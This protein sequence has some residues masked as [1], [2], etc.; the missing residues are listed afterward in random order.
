MKR[1]MT[2]LLITAA[3]TSAVIAQTTPLTAGLHQTENNAD[4]SYTGAGWSTVIDGDYSYMQS[5]QVGDLMSLEFNGSSIVLFRDMVTAPVTLT[6][7]G[8]GMMTPLPIGDVGGV[9]YRQAVQFSP[10]STGIVP[11]L[12]SILAITIITQRA[13]LAG[14]SEQIITMRRPGQYW[15]LAVQLFQLF[16]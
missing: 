4:V 2:T 3:A 8:D 16:T 1:I 11:S 13:A 5:S 9:E 6:N 10:A 15:R 14:R 7:P 12:R